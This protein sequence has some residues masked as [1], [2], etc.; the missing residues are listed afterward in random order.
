MENLTQKEKI[1]LERL[2]SCF[3]D[4]DFF[5]EV[6]LPTIKDSTEANKL[7]YSAYKK[8]FNGK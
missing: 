8:L 6:E 1:V 2:I 3:I 7:L 5:N 4:S